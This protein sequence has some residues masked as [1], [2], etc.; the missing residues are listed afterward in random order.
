MSESGPPS[1]TSGR[2]SAGQ[3]L[4]QSVAEARDRREKSRNVGALRRLAPYVRAH[5]GDATLSML[6]LVGSTSAVLGLSCAIRAL[7]DHLTKTEA[8]DGVGINS[9]FGLIAFVALA[10][11]MTT[12]LR[13]YYITKLGERVVADLRK[14]AYAHILKLDP[15]F[16]LQT[17]TGEVLSRLTTDIAIVESLLGSSISI[18]VRNLLTLLG[19]IAL[20]VFVSAKLTGLVLLLFPFVLAPLFLFGRKVRKL[21]V[22]SQDRFAE[23]VGHAGETLDALETVQAFGGEARAGATFGASV[24]LAFS[25]S[26]KRMTA[27]AVMT[28]MIIALVFGGVVAVFWLGVHAGLRGEMSWGALIQFAFLAVM[29]AGSTGA[30]GEV[31]GDVQKAAGAMERVGELLEAK[32]SIAAPSAPVAMPVPP[33][34]EIV[35]EDVTFNYPGRDDLPALRG[36]SLTVTPG[37][38]VAL[39]GPSGAGKSTRARALAALSATAGAEGRLPCLYKTGARMAAAA[40]RAG[41]T[42]R[43]VAAEAWIRPAHFCLADPALAGL[44]RKLRRAARAGISAGAAGSPLPLADMAEVAAEWARSHGGERGFSMGRWCPRYVA[45]QRVFLATHQGRLIAFL[46]LHDSPGEWTLDLL[47]SRP[48]CPDGTMYALLAAAIDAAASAGI[49][50]LSL[51]AVPRPARRPRSGKTSDGGLARFKAAFAPQWEPLYLCAPSRLA[52]AI[53]AAD[54]ARAVLRPAPLASVRASAHLEPNEIAPDTATWQGMALRPPV[55]RG[56]LLRKELL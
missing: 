3:A 33:R 2:P 38:T 39:V 35:F 55:K 29:A 31:W 22:A 27:R 9:W 32:P 36:F 12:A 15:S 46:T 41:W 16:F 50:R 4:A 47:R 30:L 17:R 8:M 6:F 53:A 51:A 49:P 40:R 42:V 52:M 44:R 43:P 20:L 18:A 14:A 13:Y 37:E 5:W 7:V 11:A 24:E 19:A 26:L 56:A 25:T 1:S 23:A 10:L 28:A 48:D 21:T 34:G 54:I 45:G